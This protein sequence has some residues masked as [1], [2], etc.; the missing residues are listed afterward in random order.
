MTWSVVRCT[1]PC[2][3]CHPFTILSEN[4]ESQKGDLWGQVLGLGLVLGVVA[5]MIGTLDNPILSLFDPWWHWIEV[6]PHHD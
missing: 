3:V 1:H 2:R 5:F 6:K 4:I